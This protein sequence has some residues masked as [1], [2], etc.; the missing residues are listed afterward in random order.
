M[1]HI[2][3]RISRQNLADWF[4]ASYEDDETGAMALGRSKRGCIVLVCRSG[5]V[6]P[7]DLQTVEE[8]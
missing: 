4:D 5:W 8:N 3:Q 7:P 6:V 1:P 2:T